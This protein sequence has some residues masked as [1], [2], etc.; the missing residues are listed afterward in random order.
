LNEVLHPE[1]LLDPNLIKALIATE[2]SFNHKAVANE[3]K[4]K[5]IAR[6][7]LQVREDS[8][9]I[10]AD[11]KGELKKHFIIV[12]SGEDLYDP[13]INICAGIRWLFHKKY[14]FHID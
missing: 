1:E 2:S 5:I 8:R 7:L 4:P 10:L 6:G 13:N 9:Q 11:Q 14:Y 12:P 3:K